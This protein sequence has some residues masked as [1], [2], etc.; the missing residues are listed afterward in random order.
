M[1]S[2]DAAI[3][4]TSTSSA[5]VVVVGEPDKATPTSP[6]PAT[7]PPLTRKRPGARSSGSGKTKRKAQGLLLVAARSSHSS[8]GG[9][10]RDDAPL[11]GMLP[12]LRSLTTTEVKAQICSQV[13]SISQVRK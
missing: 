8:F 11:L 5:S 10:E 4:T 12:S 2:E 6:A 13:N 7:K 3:A 9:D 1:A